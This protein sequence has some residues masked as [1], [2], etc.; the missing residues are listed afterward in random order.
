MVSGR[1]EMMNLRIFVA[2]LQLIRSNSGTAAHKYTA[3]S[4]R[5]RCNSQTVAEQWWSHSKLLP[6]NDPTNSASI[7][8]SKFQL[9]F[10]GETANSGN[11]SKL[12]AASNEK[13]ES[14]TIWNGTVRSQ[15]MRFNRNKQK[16]SNETR[17]QYL[18]N[19]FGRV[20]FYLMIERFN[21]QTQMP[22]WMIAK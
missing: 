5:N 22:K 16:E 21:W 7:T 20:L 14:A 3:H 8:Q 18:L 17:K 2:K 10:K 12:Y 6:C 4:V 11:A 1:T 19:L 9:V 13:N 15:W